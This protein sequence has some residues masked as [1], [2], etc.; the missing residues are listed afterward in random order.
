[1]NNRISNEDLRLCDVP[2]VDASIDALFVFALT[3]NG[4]A[5][6]GF[7][8]CAE[9]ANQQL[10]GNLTELRTCL[11]FEQRRYRHFDEDPGPEAQAYLRLLITKIREKLHGSDA[12]LPGN[13]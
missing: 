9:I 10:H 2:P 1:M 5:N 3:F 6:G 11:F 12:F 13:L 8:A 4:Y 7:D